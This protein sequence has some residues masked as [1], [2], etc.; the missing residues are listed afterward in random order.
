V[1]AIDR[2]AY[3]NRWSRVDPAQK[4][5]LALVVLLLSLLA[6]RP[7]VGLLACLWMWGAAVLGAGLPAG[8]FGWAL[9]G[10][11][12]FLVPGALGVA[13]SVGPAIQPAAG[14]G[15]Q[16]GPLSASTGPE[17]LDLA[18]R[19]STRALGAVAALDLLALT[20]PL[21]DVVQLLRRVGTPPLLVDI[22]ALA[23]RFIFILLES[24]QRMHNAQESRLGYAGFRSTM[25]SLGLLASRLFVE[26]YQRTRRVEVAMES[27]C[28][29]DDMRT[30]P[31][32]YDTAPGLWLLGLAVAATLLGGWVLT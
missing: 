17:A 6:D 3:S 14:H 27:R 21:V 2:H 19:L 26:A 23:Y 24:L 32:T 15:I 7:A 9:A 25:A 18:L 5:V 20:T 10:Q 31:S 28:L 16:L 29:S 13:V 4:G 8:V 1:L 11:A 12:A 22:V 30:L